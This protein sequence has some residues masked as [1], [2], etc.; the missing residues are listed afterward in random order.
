MTGHCVGQLD[1]V[2][3]AGGIWPRCHEAEEGM[4]QRV[5]MGV[6]QD[7]CLGEGVDLYYVLDGWMNEVQ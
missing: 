5:S 2:S 1:S 7:S 3:S 6:E 4:W